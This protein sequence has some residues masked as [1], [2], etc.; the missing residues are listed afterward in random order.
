LN[1]ELVEFVKKLDSNRPVTMVTNVDVKKDLGA[2]FVDIIA[3]N[4]YFSW[5]SDTGSLQL[6]QKQVQQEVA[7]W[8]KIYK[9]PLIFSEYGADAIS[10]YHS[11]KGKF[12]RSGI[13]IFD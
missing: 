9:K 1:R 6:I 12:M 11:V 5:Y 13:L 10:G 8:R 4:R 2:P 7:N 3:I